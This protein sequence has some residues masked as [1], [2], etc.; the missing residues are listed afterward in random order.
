[1]STPTRERFVVVLEDTCTTAVPAAARLRSVLKRLLRLFGF[2]A[3]EI[4]PAD[5]TA[6]GLPAPQETPAGQQAAQQSPRPRRFL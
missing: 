3:V 2:R 1:M 5:A 4:R 6:E